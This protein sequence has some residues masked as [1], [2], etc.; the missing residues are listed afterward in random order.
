MLKK[1]LIIYSQITWNNYHSDMK[2]RVT[3]ARCQIFSDIQ[4]RLNASMK[5]C[6]SLV[7][8]TICETVLAVLTHR[9]QSLANRQFNL[10]VLFY[11]IK[12]HMA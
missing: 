3:I 6:K 11:S 1:F 4:A 7:T 5:E 8:L 10:V 9:F 2:L 12:R